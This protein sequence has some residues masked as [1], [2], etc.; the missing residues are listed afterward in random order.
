[1]ARYFSAFHPVLRMMLDRFAFH[2]EHPVL[3][4]IRRQ[5]S[6]LFEVPAHQKQ[7]DG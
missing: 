7:L 4:D 3:R 6:H 2:Q 1:M 5:I